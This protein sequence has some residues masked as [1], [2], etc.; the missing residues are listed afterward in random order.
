MDPTTNCYGAIN[1][2]IGHTH[3]KLEDYEQA[4]VYFQ[5][6]LESEL[7][8][9]QAGDALLSKAHKT[10]GTL[11]AEKGD[12]NL[13]LEFCLQFLNNEWKKKIIRRFLVSGR[14]SN[15]RWH[16]LQEAPVERSLTLL[17]SP[18]RLL[19]AKTTHR[20]RESI[21]HLSSDRQRV[22]EEASVR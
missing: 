18:T 20:S 11:Y 9:K 12:I 10:L 19:P 5:K 22:A 8:R 6:V 16:L 13:A 1:L 4:I 21:G 7:Q 2:T 14:L 15:D 17:Q 3:W